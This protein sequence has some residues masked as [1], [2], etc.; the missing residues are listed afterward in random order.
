M[1]SV[2]SVTK[3][4]GQSN[5]THSFTKVNYGYE[6]MHVKRNVLNGLLQNSCK[7]WFLNGKHYRQDGPAILQSGQQQEDSW[8]DH[9][10]LYFS[11]TCFND[12]ISLAW[13]K[14]GWNHR[15]NGPSHIVL[16]KTGTMICAIWCIRGKHHRKRGPAYYRFTNNRV[17]LEWYYMG[18]LTKS[19]SMEMKYVKTKAICSYL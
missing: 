17:Y 16:S 19:W 15:M 11:R 4:H 8:F 5:V 9:D 6:T 1:F 18:I 13:Y 14:N 10:G 3:I 12:V 2:H 7:V